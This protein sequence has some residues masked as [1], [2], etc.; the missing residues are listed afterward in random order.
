MAIKRYKPTTPARR[1]MTGFDFSEITTQ[2]PDKGLLQKKS[3]RAGRSAGKISMR[4]RGGGAKQRYRL[5]DLKRKKMDIPAKV[6]SIEYDPNR[7]CRIAKIIYDDGWKSYILAPQGLK[8]GDKVITSQD[9]SLKPGNRLKLKNIPTGSQIYN[10]EINPG[11]GGQIVRAA[12]QFASLLSKEEKYVTIQLPSKEV[13]KVLSECFAS[14]GALSLPEKSLIKFGKAGRKR[15]F[16]RR[17]RVRGLA[18][19]PNAHPHGGGE[20]RSSIGLSGPKSPWGKSTL[21]KKTRKSKPSD[22][23][24][25]KR[26]K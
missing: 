25:I 7:T 6:V 12:G 2:K 13:R 20:G 10:I 14:I 26:R 1:Q 16:G 17:P 21:G 18:M 15:W 23:L 4:R 3:N 8:I 19:A 5:V 22:K 11:K 24:I 9:G